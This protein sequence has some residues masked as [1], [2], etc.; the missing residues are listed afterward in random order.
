MRTLEQSTARVLSLR[1]AGVLND[2][3]GVRIFA[4][5]GRVANLIINPVNAYGETERNAAKGMHASH[6]QHIVFA[7]GIAAAMLA[8]EGS[9][10][11]EA[12]GEEELMQ[13]VTVFVRRYFG[14]PD[15]PEAAE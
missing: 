6:A 2:S 1:N 13:A 9:E 14:L 11:Y 8:E 4:A 3:F 5:L 10:I 12:L 7:E 15:A